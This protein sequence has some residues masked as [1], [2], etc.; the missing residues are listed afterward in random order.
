MQWNIFLALWHKFIQNALEDM[1]K[2]HALDFWKKIWHNPV[3]GI[4]WTH[5]KHVSNWVWLDV[6]R[7]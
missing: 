3:L 7:S 6:Y 2:C 4:K 5:N 1:V